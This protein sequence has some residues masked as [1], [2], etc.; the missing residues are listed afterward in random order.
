MRGNSFH[1]QKERATFDV[2]APLPGLSDTRKKNEPRSPEGTGSSAALK[3]MRIKLGLDVMRANHVLGW[4][5]GGGGKCAPE[6][7]NTTACRTFSG[8]S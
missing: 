2:K 8:G 5:G 1:K 4:S 6:W 3:S 7:R